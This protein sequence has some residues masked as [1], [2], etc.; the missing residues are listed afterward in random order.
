MLAIVRASCVEIAYKQVVYVTSL[1][2]DENLVHLDEG[3]VRK[4]VV[5]LPPRSL[6]I[7]TRCRSL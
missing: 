7:Q 1:F 2:C 5:I 4:V 3:D 6:V